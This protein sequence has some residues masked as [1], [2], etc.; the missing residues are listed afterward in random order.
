MS[1]FCFS[2]GMPLEKDNK[3]GNYCIYCTDE[4]G[5]LLAEDQ[6]KNG[7]AQW[8]SGWASDNKNSD[9]MKRAGLYMKS[10]PEWAD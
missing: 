8:L 6:I 5:N 3:R 4:Q 1:V 9:F 10:M 2:C 7:I